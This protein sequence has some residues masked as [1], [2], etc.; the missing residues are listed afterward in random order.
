MINS[1]QCRAARGFLGWSRKLLA[2]HA[3]ISMATIASFEEER[4][5]PQPHTI[6][7]LEIA[8][9]QEGVEFESGPGEI[10]TV[11]LRGHH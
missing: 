5:T 1:S 9:E 2:D 7:Q 3:G 11:S 10:F 8:F 4:R 6:R